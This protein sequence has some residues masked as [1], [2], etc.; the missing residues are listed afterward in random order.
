[1]LASGSALA[2]V[3]KLEEKVSA[4]ALLDEHELHRVVESFNAMQAF[5]L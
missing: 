5:F 2:M 3:R 4:I 1:M